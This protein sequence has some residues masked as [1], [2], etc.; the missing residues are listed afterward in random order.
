MAC[1]SC[2]SSSPVVSYTSSGC[3]AALGTTV[4]CLMP[5]RVSTPSV[6]PV[7][8]T[9]IPSMIQAASGK[10]VIANGEDFN[11]LDCAYDG[12]VVFDSASGKIYVGTTSAATVVADNFACETSTLYGFPIY[13]LDPGCRE[14]GANP[15]RNMAVVRPAESTTGI[16][17]GHRHTCSSNT[18]MSEEISPVE[19]VPGTMPSPLP[20]DIRILSFRRVTA[21][22]SCSP[23]TFEWY[24][25]DGIPIVMPDDMLTSEPWTA[26]DITAANDSE[27]GFAMW[28]LVDGKWV[29]KKLTN[30]TFLAMIRQDDGASPIKHVRPRPVIYSQ[31]NTGAIPT[32]PFATVNTNYNL[33]AAANYD[34]KYS[35]VIL[36]ISLSAYTGTRGFDLFVSIDGE[37]FARVKVGTVNGSD[38]MSTQIMVPIPASK[39]IN[40]KA[41]EYTNTVGG[42]YGPT[43]VIVKLDG[44]M[45]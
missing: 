15:D 20:N 8:F 43:E 12:P 17:F 38:S 34:A 9:W 23:A 7:A 39:Q 1:T 21:V 3:G 28:G 37:E 27:F 40:I 2:S 33:A 13:G 30:E 45:L 10:A 41:Q 18:S 11:V 35:T 44:F 25:H 22:D 6:T 4:S 24:D 29:L 36:S 42:T 32:T 16:L 26:D 14:V 19:I 5:R 31:S